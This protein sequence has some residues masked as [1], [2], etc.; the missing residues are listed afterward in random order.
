MVDFYMSWKGRRCVMVSFCRVV[1]FS[2]RFA[3]FH[4][5][6]LSYTPITLFFHSFDLFIFAI[7]SP[8]FLTCLVSSFVPVHTRPFHPVPTL[9]VSRHREAFTVLPA[10]TPFQSLRIGFGG[11]RFRVEDMPLVLI[12]TLS[13][14]RRLH[15]SRSRRN[16]SHPRQANTH[17]G[18]N[19]IYSS[20]YVVCECASAN[21]ASTPSCPRADGG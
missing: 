13:S 18:P 14:S 17:I 11:R 21:V 6:R 10:L 20:A 5:S 8:L 7:T 9:S 12:A 19:P 15:S 16:V 2:L 4:F 1:W 3:S